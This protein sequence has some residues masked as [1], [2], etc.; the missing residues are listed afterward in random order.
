MKKILI[1]LFLIGLALPALGHSQ[2][3]SGAALQ[4]KIA[5]LLKILESLKVQ[6]LLLQ[7]RPSPNLD[8]K[9]VV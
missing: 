9:S 7:S 3:L 5:E 8:R 1:I 4:A 6:V 2:T